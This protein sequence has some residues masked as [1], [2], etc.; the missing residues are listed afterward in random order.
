MQ[1]KPWSLKLF[2]FVAL[3]IGAAYVP[4]WAVNKCAG[5]HG[6]TVFQ[7]A[8]CATSGVTVA[9]DLAQKKA[10]AAQKQADLSHAA[11]DFKEKEDAQREAMR[12]DIQKKV[13]AAMAKNDAVIAKAKASCDGDVVDYPSIGMSELHF[14]NCTSWGLLNRPKTVNETETA[15]GVSKQFVYA[16]G[17]EIR[18]LYTVNGKVTAIQR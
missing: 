8:P 16:P 12:A 10:T 14:Q 2:C 7:D 6:Q 4:A 11:A 15:R 5:P 17:R 18:Y 13:Q 3:T 1:R 9:E